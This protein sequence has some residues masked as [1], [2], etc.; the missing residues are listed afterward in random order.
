MPNMTAGEAGTAID[1]LYNDPTV[2]PK[3][4]VYAVVRLVVDRHEDRC[5]MPTGDG[6]VIA[7][8]RRDE[9][10]GNVQRAINAARNFAAV[11]RSS[12]DGADLVSKRSDDA[13]GFKTKGMDGQFHYGVIAFSPMNSDENGGSYIDEFL[14]HLNF[15]SQLNEQDYGNVVE[16]C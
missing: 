4:G 7:S 16:R 1:Q 12:T 13:R 8:D 15:Y 2:T 14:R 10:D 3:S 11:L 9:V 5:R 6:D